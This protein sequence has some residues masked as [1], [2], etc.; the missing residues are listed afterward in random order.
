M[1]FYIDSPKLRF[2]IWNKIDEKLKKDL[3]ENKLILV[4]KHVTEIK[5]DIK[6]LDRCEPSISTH[7]E[8]KQLRLSFNDFYSIDNFIT[9][10]QGH[11][12]SSEY[13]SIDELASIGYLIQKE[14]EE[15][16]GYEINNPEIIISIEDKKF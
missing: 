11:S 4:L 12:A 7:D 1:S 15:C 8:S 5:T 14:L 10:E 16:L 2:Q 13:F 6:L 3:V 9:F